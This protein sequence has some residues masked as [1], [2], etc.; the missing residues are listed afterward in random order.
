MAYSPT[1][2]LLSTVPVPSPVLS[3]KS[4]LKCSVLFEESRLRFL[5]KLEPDINEDPV[6][7][8]RTNGIDMEDFVYGKYDDHH[9]YYE[10]EDK[11][12]FWGSIAEDYA[13][14]GPPT[15]FQG[16]ISWLFLPAIAAADIFN[17]QGVFVHWA[18]VFT[19]VFCIIEMDKP[20][21]PTILSLKYTTWKG[22]RDKLIS[23]YNTMNIWEFNEKYGDIWDFTSLRMGS[24]EDVWSRTVKLPR[25]RGPEFLDLASIGDLFS[26][27]RL[28]IANPSNISNPNTTLVND[29][30]LLAVNPTV[31]P[32]N[33]DIGQAISSQFLQVPKQDTTPD[34]NPN[35]IPHQLSSSS[36]PSPSSSPPAAAAV[37]DE[38]DRK[39]AVI[40]LAIALGICGLLL[41]LGVFN[42][43]VEVNLMADVSECLDKYKMYKIEQ[44]WEATDGFDEGCLIQGS[45]YKGTIDGEVFAVKKMK[46]NAREELKILQKVNHG[47]LVKL[48]GFCIDPKEANCYLVY[49]YVENGSLHSWL[50]GTQGTS[51]LVPLGGIVSTKMDVFSFGVVLLELVSGKEAIDDEGKVLWAKVGDFSEGSEERKV[52]KLQEWMDESLLREEFTMESVVNV[53]GVAVSCL[54]K[55]PSRRP[56]MVEIV[57]ALSKSIDL[58]SDVSEEGLSPRQVTAR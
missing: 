51:P 22:A 44:L 54:N 11:A 17:V 12:T 48:E 32:E 46:W 24:A 18:A 21:K 31:V 19:I 39:G 52:R 41:I 36:K 28:M 20:V 2:S 50:H 42:K 45:V 53:M 30:P 55:D 15:G 8:W 3:T 35:K 40:G 7:R 13:A 56:G 33:I 37:V 58:F 29:Q 49:E 34:P 23:D 9:T 10:S 14:V 1:L 6:D 4:Q 5:P 25:A 43:D 26:V 47:N 38:N 57:Y 16:I 27:S